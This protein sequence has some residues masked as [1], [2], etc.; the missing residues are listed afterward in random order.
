MTPMRPMSGSAV[1]DLVARARQDLGRLVD[2][3][4]TAIREQVDC[5]RHADVVSADEL[6][7]SIS[8]NLGGLLDALVEPARS[9]HLGAAGETGRTRARQRAPLPEVLQAFRIGN[10]MLW[11]H[12]AA[13]VRGT[14]DL[15]S[16]GAFAEVA[17][18]LWHLCDAQAQTLTEVYRDAT[19]E[20]VAA[21]E[22]RRSALVDALFSGQIVLN[23]GPWEVG[24][25]LGLSLD[26]SLV[27]VVVETSG[28][29]QDG[30]AVVEKRLAE[31]GM[32]SAWHVNSSL[33]AGVIS[34]R[35]D[36]HGLMLRVLREA[37]ATRA[38]LSPV[39]RSLA[40]TPRA[41]HLA[42]TAL[43]EIPPGD[44][45][46]REFSPSPLAGLV[47]RDPDEGRRMA[48]DVLG[49]VLD[50]PVED[51]QGL[52]ETLRAFFDEGG[53]TERTARALHCH[54]NTVRYRLH[55]IAELTGRSLSEPRALAELVTATY[56]L[57]Q[58]DDA[59]RGGTFP[60]R[61]T[62]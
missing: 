21:Q 41:F 44:A 51:R 22:R 42:R 16:L 7:Q 11:D 39:Y 19:A 24:K 25:M 53:S 4:Y 28:P 62:G 43:A 54:P 5:Y 50:L 45:A 33:Y 20:L 47:A 26:G 52:L 17:T 3:A 58:H 34:L 23:S 13:Q 38:G 60:R 18:L 56:A 40:D 15:R 37:G 10:T 27:V 1:H 55:R 8:H 32:I 36:Q 57:G 30:R 12:L 46:L 31:H 48:Q 6:R 14:V 35:D 29:P 61:P 59:R 2:D 9:A 49:A